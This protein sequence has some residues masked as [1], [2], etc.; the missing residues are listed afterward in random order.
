MPGH[1]EISRY[2]ISDGS[3]ELFIQPYRSLLGVTQLYLDLTL[4]PQLFPAL[5]AANTSLLIIHEN[6]I[7]G[8]LSLVML[9]R[10]P[11]ASFGFLRYSYTT[12]EFSGLPLLARVLTEIDPLDLFTSFDETVPGRMLAKLRY[13]LVGGISINMAASDFCTTIKTT[14]ATAAL[15]WIVLD[16]NMIPITTSLINA[17]S[18]TLGICYKPICH[19]PPTPSPKPT[20]SP[21]STCLAGHTEIARYSISDGSTEFFIQPY[22]SLLGIDK[23][24]LDLTLRPHLLPALSPANSSLLVLHEN[25]ITGGLSLIV[26][27]RPPTTPFDLGLPYSYTTMHISGLPLLAQVLTKID[28]LDLFTSFDGTIPGQLLA[29][30]R[31][32]RVGGVA[33]NMAMSEFCTT[34]ETTR[35]TAALPWIVLDQ[36]TIPITTSMTNAEGTSLRICYK[37]TCQS[38]ILPKPRPSAV[39]SPTPSTA[40]DECVKTPRWR[41]ESEGWSALFI[42][43]YN[44]EIPS[45]K[46]YEYRRGQRPGIAAKLRADNST[47]IMVHHDTKKDFYNLL[48]YIG[49]PLSATTDEF[50]YYKMRLFDAPPNSAMPVQD[51]PLSRYDVM[52][53]VTDTEFHFQWRLKRDN[54]DGVMINMKTANFCVR[55]NIEQN[56]YPSQWQFVSGDRMGKLAT[57][58]PNAMGTEMKI[59]YDPYCPSNL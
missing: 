2:S 22:R 46:L 30:L 58:L 38:P 13:R 39:P 55:L 10:P 18:T 57:T 15:P 37:P 47:L 56:S 7:T 32:S 9:V 42:E 40:A 8:A 24:Y 1:T 23:L 17:E 16:Q 50:A 14:R 36:S 49:S 59:C 4:R 12:M 20:P 27:V 43:P 6:A 11:K 44:S 34:I 53:K 3:S 19:A 31:Y 35:A 51:D 29:K 48:I 45:R 54:A 5:S 21:T 52:Q 25:P 41:V 28:P 26:L 33:I